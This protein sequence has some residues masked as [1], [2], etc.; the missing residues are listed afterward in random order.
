MKFMWGVVYIKNKDQV[1][2]DEFTN[3]GFMNLKFCGVFCKSITSLACGV[4]EPYKVVSLF[5]FILKLE[6][7]I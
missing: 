1:G 2:G 6:N 3:L 4:K 7:E 5:N